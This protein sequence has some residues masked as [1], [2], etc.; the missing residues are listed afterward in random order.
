MLE[1][2]KERIREV[3]SPER[4]EKV[5]AMIEKMCSETRPPL[6]SIPVQP[7]DEDIFITTTIE[8]A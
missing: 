7:N 5:L 1:E 6:M 8:D 2:L 3:P 4:L